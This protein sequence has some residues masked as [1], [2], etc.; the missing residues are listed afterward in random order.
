MYEFMNLA[1]LAV[2]H[3]L[4]TW[5][6]VHIIARIGTRKEGYWGRHLHDIKEILRERDAYR[7]PV[8]ITIYP[9]EW[10]AI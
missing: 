1:R 5:R 3:G 8:T 6:E 7:H 9:D 4:L 2:H 10:E